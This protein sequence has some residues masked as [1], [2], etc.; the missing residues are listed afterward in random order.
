V[1]TPGAKSLE[2]DALRLLSSLWLR[3]PDADMVRLA[4][5]LL[6]LPA[7]EP[8]ELAAAYAELF[9]LNVY[10]YGTVFTDPNGELNG[11]RAQEIARLYAAAGYQPPEL[12]Q[13]GAPDHLGA[14]LGFAAHLAERQLDR[15]DFTAELLDWAPVCC[16]AVER[17]P[18]AHPLYQSLA[19]LTREWLLAGATGS[20]RDTDSD[21]ASLFEL[22]ISSD[23]EVSL[24]GLVRFFL[25]P[26]RCGIFLSRGQLGRMAVSLGMRL[27][28]GS[29]FEVAEALFQAAGEGGR[30]EQLIAALE[31][32]INL[33]RTEYSRWAQGQPNWQ[34]VAERW[35][36]RTSR[37]IGQLSEMR[38]TVE[39]GLP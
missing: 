30:V 32:E 10:P 36:A 37:A 20:G 34:A 29:R 9:L 4:T 17:E 14:C 35:L 28:F 7:A 22:S 38:K 5:S 31:A 18:T 25:A 13:I 27:P 8:A 19:R 26:A 1:S 12:L 21:G 39:R 11:P 3:E 24:R 16:L 6:G 33:W 23:E 2:L 15:A